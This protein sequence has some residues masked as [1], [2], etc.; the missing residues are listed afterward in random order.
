MHGNIDPISR[1]VFQQQL[2]GIAEEMSM[3]L[4]RAAFSSI[5]WDMYDYA[6]GLLLPDGPQ[7]HGS[8]HDAPREEYERQQPCNDA[9]PGKGARLSQHQQQAALQTYGTHETRGRDPAGEYRP[10]AFIGKDCQPDSEHLHSDS[11]RRR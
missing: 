1:D 5:I 6:C 3:A 8:H 2:V 4:R 9:V 7:Q 11:G 10:R